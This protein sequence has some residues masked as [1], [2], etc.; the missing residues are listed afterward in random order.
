MFFLVAKL[1]RLFLC[2][3]DGEGSIVGA[4]S[5]NSFNF[6]I[7]LSFQHFPLGSKVKNKGKRKQECELT[8]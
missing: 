7:S 3:I 6:S 5:V 4:T 2:Q 8:G 1:R